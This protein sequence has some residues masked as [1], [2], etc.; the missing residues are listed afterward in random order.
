MPAPS[1][2]RP[3]SAT[4]RYRLDIAR[5]LAVAAAGG[6]PGRGPATLRAPQPEEDG[7]EDEPGAG[8]PHRAG[9]PPVG[10]GLGGRG[11]S[12]PLVQP[13]ERDEGR[14]VPAEDRH[15]EPVGG[16]H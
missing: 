1:S 15:G 7:A 11:E 10:G 3:T 16:D 12:G 8:D 13:E 5:K 9:Q 6:G 2:T 4:R 14:H